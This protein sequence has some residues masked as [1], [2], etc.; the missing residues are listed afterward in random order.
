MKLFLFLLL[1]VT[2]FSPAAQSPMEGAADSRAKV[3]TYQKGEVYSV[4][5]HTGISTTIEFA[6]GEVYESHQTGFLN[7]WDFVPNGRFLTLKPRLKHGDSNVTVF[8]NK[9]QYLFA[10]KARDPNKYGID[11][12]NL[13]YYLE[14]TYPGEDTTKAVVLHK[15]RLNRATR[16][17]ERETQYFDPSKLSFHYYFSGDKEIAPVIAF[18]NGQFTYLKIAKNS[19]VPAV[20]AVDRDRTES[21]VNTRMEGD[22]VVIEQLLSDFT[23]RH[24]NQIVSV[25]RNNDR[26]LLTEARNNEK[27]VQNDS[28]A[29]W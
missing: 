9:R 15:E 13:N 24:G 21:V 11:D 8:T 29:P 7:A 28:Y 27:S 18:D 22:Y 6:E 3:L 1:F 12:Q 4:T 14:F 20:Y 19:A 10:L 16:E 17:C 2:S 26:E 23:L 5:A 25:S